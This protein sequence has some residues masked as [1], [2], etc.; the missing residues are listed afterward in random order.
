MYRP[1]HLTL[2]LS[3]QLLP[4]ERAIVMGIINVTPDSFYSTSR[5]RKSV[6]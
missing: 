4:L 5:D 3:G 2:N 1:D 6:V